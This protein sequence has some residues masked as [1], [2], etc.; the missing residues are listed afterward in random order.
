MRLTRAGLLRLSSTPDPKNWRPHLLVLSG[1][2]TRRW[3][4]IELATSFTHNQALM[5]VATVVT[6]PAVSPQRLHALEENIR[7]FLAKRGVQTLVRTV[8]ARSAFEGAESL[9]SS[10]GL[11]GLVPNTLVLGDTL[12]PG[13]LKPY[14]DMIVH[15]HQKKRNVVIVRPNEDR[16]FG[17]RK[18]IDVWWGGLKGNGGLMKILAYMLQTS[19]DWRDAEVRIKIVVPN[20]SAAAGVESN[21]APIVNRLRTGATLDVLVSEGRSFD[22]ILRSSSAD[23]D[24]IFLGMAA[25]SESIDF[26]S[27]YEQLRARTDGMPTTVFVLAAEDIGFEEVLA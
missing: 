8:A 27:Y 9:I 25:P 22:E 6:D 21:L 16:L 18:R 4:L 7:D 5:T 10:Y 17:E 12:E 11:G 15:F 2:P 26:A 1:A 20:N 19:I 3:Y 13:H 14:C 23:A 24:L